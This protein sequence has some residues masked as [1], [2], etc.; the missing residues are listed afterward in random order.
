MEGQASDRVAECDP[1]VFIAS[2]QRCNADIG[3][4]DETDDCTLG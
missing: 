2:T 4:Q 1:Y 3:A